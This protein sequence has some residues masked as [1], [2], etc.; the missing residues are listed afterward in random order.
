MLAVGYP[1]P[2]KLREYAQ[3]FKLNCTVDTLIHK[4]SI[5]HGYP[6]A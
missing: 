3:G 2:H 6:R 5:S 1:L 4:K